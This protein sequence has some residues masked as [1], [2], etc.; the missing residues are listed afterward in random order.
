[1]LGWFRRYVKKSLEPRKQFGNQGEAEAAR[2]LTGLG[3]EVLQRQLRGRFGELDLV[4]IDRGT[5]VFVEVKTRSSTAAGHP[6]ES[7]NLTK[8]RKITRSA[9]AFLKQRRWL[10]K[11]ARF[12]VVSIIWPADDQPP[13]I[14]HYINAFEPVGFGQ[15]YS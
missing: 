11:S 8:Q 9:L 7:V 3:Y 5:I 4:A 14:Q 12:D 10:N 1:M 13:Q 6:T 15:M 2:F